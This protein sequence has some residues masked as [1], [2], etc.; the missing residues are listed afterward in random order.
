MMR[1]LFIS[2]LAFS[3]YIYPVK[4]GSGLCVLFKSS[5]RYNTLTSDQQR[6]TASNVSP[7]WTAYSCN[8]KE[9]FCNDPAAI[10]QRLMDCIKNYIRGESDDWLDAYNGAMY[11]YATEC[12]TFQ[13]Q[14]KDEFT[15]S[16][17]FD[18]T[19]PTT[20]P[21]SNPNPDPGVQAIPTTDTTQRE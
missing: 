12:G 19:Y 2:A 8:E 7:A 15:Q 1:L 4:A 13:F 16:V 17:T 6:C 5:S 3:C 9:C 21:A 10:D 18:K 20:P 11:F 14:K